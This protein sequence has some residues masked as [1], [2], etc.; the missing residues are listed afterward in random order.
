ME[1]DMIQPNSHPRQWRFTIKPFPLFDMER[2]RE[3]GWWIILVLTIAT[4]AL[5]TLVRSWAD[6]QYV[7]QAELDHYL[8]HPDNTV[9]P[10]QPPAMPTV[11]KVMRFLGQ[12]LDTTGAWIGWAGGLY[13]VGL[14]LRQREARF[15]TTLKVVAWSWLPFV[16]RG[17]AQCLYMWLTQDPIFNPGLSG[18]VWDNT[19]PPPGGGY[20][21]VMPTQGQLVW[22]AL[23]AHLDVYLL[24]HLGLTVNGLRS[25]AAFK[26][27]K[28]LL[29]TAIVALFLGTVGLLPT[30][31]GDTFSRLR[32]F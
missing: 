16:V 8:A 18:L 1:E 17:L 25:L 3:R 12:M 10:P 31:F 28:A 19:P 4:I 24:W 14:L 15:V 30:V 11:T 2:V 29:V 7:Y 21:Y 22:S 26:G 23:L 20:V 5:T 13:L 27:K 32:L 9:R 6:C